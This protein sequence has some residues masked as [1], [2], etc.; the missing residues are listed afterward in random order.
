M[1]GVI[2]EVLGIAAVR[3]TAADTDDVLAE[4]VRKRVPNLPRRT[5]VA[6]AP[7]EHPDQAVQRARPP[8]TK[9]A[10]AS[11]LACSWSN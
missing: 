10:P 2:G 5:P 11:A 3:L 9:T 4:Q 8:L 7:G 6:Q 1:D